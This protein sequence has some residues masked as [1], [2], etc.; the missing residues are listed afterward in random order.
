[1][2]MFRRPGD[3]SSSDE[4]S[5]D[6]EEQETSHQTRQDDAHNLSRINTLD[7]GTSGG[8]P[9]H[10]A[11]PSRPAM[12]RTNTEF[13]DLILH[14]LLE[15]KALRE[16]A[17]HLGKDR[18][19]PEVQELAR[20][21]YRALSRQMSTS[22]DDS[23]ASDEMRSHRA[24]AQDGINAATRNYLTGLSASTAGD[25]LAL[26][27]LP[28]S[29]GAIP[30]SSPLGFDP[31]PGMAASIDMPLRGYPGLHE[32]RYVREF[33]EF[34][35]V[36]KGGYG[37]V[38]KVKHKLDNSFYAVKR[39]IVSSSRLQKIKEHGP[40]EMESLLEEVRS[41]ARFDHGNIV[42]YHNAWLE[43]S[44]G[45]GVPEHAAS[46]HQTRR[47][48]E[49]HSQDSFD[50]TNDVDVSFGA[51]SIEDPFSNTNQESGTNIVF[52]TSD[53]GG[54]AEEYNRS[55]GNG[56]S[57]GHLRAPARKNRRGSHASQ[58]TVAT[59]SSTKSLMSA[60]ESADEDEE[61]DEIETIPRTHLPYSQEETTTDMSQSML[62]N[63]DIPSHMVST[64]STGPILT[65][66]VQMSL[67]DTNLAAFLN[68]EQ[69][70]FRE[71]PQL[72]HCFHSCVSLEL[73]SNIIAGV[74]YLHA[75]GV[76][77]RDMKPANVFLSLSTSRIPPSGSI[78]LSSCK[79]CPQRE[80]VYVTPR[81]GDFGLVAALGDKCL[82]SDAAAKPVGTEFYR[83]EGGDATISEK[84]DVFALGVVGFEML[85]KFDTRMERVDALVN[86]RRGKFP[87]KFTEKIGSQGEEIRDLI[88]KMVDVDEKKRPTCED[89]QSELG[90][91]VRALKA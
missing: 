76:V 46:F 30:N 32:N 9:G 58:A 55:N 73:L 25:S 77:H 3:S 40:Q 15:D 35:I 90:S 34:D 64:R 48:I 27:P 14:S 21:T 12:S 33:E 85:R 6:S 72:H 91:I 31:L 16:A 5:E 87:P 1:M 13:R 39:I 23:Y 54:G 53:T 78:N 50:H 70:S 49:G 57:K 47:Y 18:S 68:E 4:S 19:D 82:V 74:E 66:N 60:I 59:I 69:V 88:S 80:C 81:I 7:S 22:V 45:P 52:E 41:L 10:G 83:P 26:V 37:K 67:Y 20:T 36:G 71:K 38:Y 56:L 29:S 62:S 17:E 44:A 63:S 8:L 89:V 75:Q 65:L 43:F 2:S 61:D 24:A 28:F 86:L 11:P 51:L 42:R 84:L 79:P